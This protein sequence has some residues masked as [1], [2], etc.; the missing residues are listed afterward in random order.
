MKQKIKKLVNP[1][2]YKRLFSYVRRNGV[3][4]LRSKIRNGFYEQE[5]PNEVYPQWFEKNRL[6]EAEEKKQRTEAEQFAYM[7]KISLIVPTY[8]TPPEFLAEMI[9]SVQNQ[10]YP[11]WELCIADGST[12]RRTKVMIRR[13]RREDDR[14]RVRYLDENLGISENTNK[15]LALASGDFI[16]L[17]DHDDKLEPDLL[18][19]LVKEL[20][21][22]KA[23][24]V[25]TDEDRIVKR[26]DKWIHTDPVFKPDMSPDLLFSHNYI[27]HFFLAPKKLVKDMGGF[28]KEFDGAQDYDLIL[29]VTEHFNFD[30]DVIR[31]VPRIL[32]HWRI[33]EESTAGNPE[34]KMYCYEAGRMALDQHFERMGIAAHAEHTGMWGLYHAVYDTPGNPLVSIIIP[35]KDHRDDLR[36]CIT[37]IVEK[38]SYRNFEFIIVENNSVEPETFSYYEELEAE[39]DFVKVVKWDKGFNYAAINN[40][41]ARAASGDYYLLL[42]NDTELISP[43]AISDMLGILM[44]KDVGI[45]GAKLLFGDDTVQH[46]GVVLGFGQYGG[47]AGHV[48]SGIAADGLGYMMRPCINCNYSAVTGACLMVKKQVFDEVNGLTEEFTVSL[49]DVDFCLKAREKGYLV[50]YDAFARWHHYESKSRGYETTPEKEERFIGEVKLFQKYWEHLLEK[51]DPY[52]NR[53]FPVTIAPFTLQL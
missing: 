44:R 15:A 13:Y 8:N 4:G 6:H 27:T 1:T 26:G 28:R 40:F 24:V 7:P 37:S 33:H 25:Y 12:E 38:S 3:K 43:D 41:G 50:V 20:Q 39:Y 5:S 22:R 53:N 34:S 35:N 42:N 17:L 2:N 14:L 18:F 48:F 29:R 21:D 32:Y 19:E 9:E 49:N 51:G 45:V 36:T 46:A 11:N 16:G 47:F 23:Q 10:T 52:Y 31:H 30:P